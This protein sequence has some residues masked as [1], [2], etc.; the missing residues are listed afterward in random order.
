LN[1][2]ISKDDIS[3]LVENMTTMEENLEQHK[4]DVNDKN[5]T[6]LNATAHHRNSDIEIDMDDYNNDNMDGMF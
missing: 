5:T 4:F 1:H 3:R 2:K 6:L